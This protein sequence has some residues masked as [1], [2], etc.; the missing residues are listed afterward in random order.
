MLGDNILDNLHTEKA[1]R[2]I[3]ILGI[4]LI[5]LLCEFLSWNEMKIE[6]IQDSN[7]KMI[8]SNSS[9]VCIENAYYKQLRKNEISLYI[10]GWCILKNRATQP[11]AMFIILKDKNDNMYKLPTSIIRREDVTQVIDDGINYDNS[12]F[13]VNMICS[14]SQIDFRIEIYEICVLCIYD[15]EEYIIE[16]GMNVLLNEE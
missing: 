12:G 16:S 15:N 6:R 13:R 2:R 11:V 9:I 5:I 3:L 14:Y 1:I 10:E 8:E 4:I 7:Y